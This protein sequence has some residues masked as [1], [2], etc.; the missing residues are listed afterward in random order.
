ML[1]SAILCFSVNFFNSY[2][3]DFLRGHN[4]TQI[5]VS[6]LTPD[7]NYN[8]T[9]K[10]VG[11]AGSMTEESFPPA[12]ATTRMQIYYLFFVES[13]ANNWFFLDPLAPIRP[14]GLR[15]TLIRATYFEIAWEPMLRA[16][17]YEVL[18][19]DESRQARIMFK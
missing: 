11:I 3:F 19:V 7:T 10:A 12:Q 16:I 2:S 4:S 18:V 5:I 9:I 1:F 14:F 6:S 13:L 8:V 17:A 15:V